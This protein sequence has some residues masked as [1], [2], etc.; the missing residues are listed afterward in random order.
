[1]LI[2]RL[3]DAWNHTE[4][5][6]YLCTSANIF[7]I[8]MST[9][10]KSA[11]ATVVR[12]V[13]DYFISSYLRTHSNVASARPHVP[14]ERGGRWPLPELIMRSVCSASAC[15]DIDIDCSVRIAARRFICEQWSIDCY[16]YVRKLAR[17]RFDYV[18]HLL[19]AVSTEPD[20]T[21]ILYWNNLRFV[22]IVLFSLL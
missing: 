11:G 5:E 4:T 15:F 3:I 17:K 2:I 6:V 7:R 18:Y 1:M 9:Q 14:G 21:C 8:A 20:T 13:Y 12:H 22:L 10:A 19:F 16:R